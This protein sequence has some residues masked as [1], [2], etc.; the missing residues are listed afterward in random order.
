MEVSFFFFNFPM[1]HDERDMWKVFQRQGRLKDVFISRRLNVKRQRFGFVR[2][3]EVVDV[4]ALEKRLNLFW[5]RTWKLRVNKPKYRRYQES[6]KEGNGSHITMQQKHEWR[7]K[8]H[9]LT[10]AQ[11]VGKENKNRTQRVVEQSGIHIKVEGDSGKWLQKCFIG[12]V[13][14]VEKLQTVR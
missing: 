14:D 13:A 11:A 1:D 12:R 2:F 8:D 10:Y 7:Q 9:R 4:V 6:R 5:I 3:Q